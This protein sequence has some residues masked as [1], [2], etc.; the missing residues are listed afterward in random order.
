MRVCAAAAAVNFAPL[1]ATEA[2]PEDA[3]VK[4]KLPGG[5]GNLLRGVLFLTSRGGP[6][7]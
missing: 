6:S 2:V 5:Q 4:L 1:W 7:P 3:H